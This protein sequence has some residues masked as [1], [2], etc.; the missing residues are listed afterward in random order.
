[1]SGGGSGKARKI[2]KRKQSFEHSDGL[3]AS[4][5]SGLSRESVYSTVDDSI[6]QYFSEVKGH[7]DG[8]DDTEERSRLA[9][10]AL[11]ETSGRELQIAT[12][13]CCSRIL[14]ALLPCAPTPS[15][16]QF[17]QALLSPPTFPTVI[18]K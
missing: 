8:L 17:C 16:T 18:R 3:P 1:M 9:L 15:I 13:V 4:K 6:L 10:N 12:D 5:R 7:F 2:K 14:E 11:E